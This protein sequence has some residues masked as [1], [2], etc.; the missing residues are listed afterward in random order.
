MVWAGTA[1]RTISAAATSA[2]SLVTARAGGKAM[3]G[4]R[5][6]LRRSAASRAAASGVR[7]HRMVRRPARALRTASAVP[8]APEPITPMAGSETLTP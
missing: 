7:V 2:P 4:S 1:S 8:Q 6:S 3:P 5:A